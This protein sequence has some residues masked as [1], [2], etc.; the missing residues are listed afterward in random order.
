MVINWLQLIPILPAILQTL[1][2]LPQTGTGTGL[3]QQVNPLL[4]HTLIILYR[5]NTDA[6]SRQILLSMIQ[7][8]SYGNTKVIEQ[9]IDSMK[10][11]QEQIKKLEEM[12]EGKKG[13]FLSK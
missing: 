6:E 2:V 8:L 12:L 1:G 3:P 13:S 7:L 4:I 11:S 9:I 10:E 5:Q